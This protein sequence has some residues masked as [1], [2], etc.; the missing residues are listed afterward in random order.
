MGEKH[1]WRVRLAVTIKDKQY[2]SNQCWLIVAPSIQS[3]IK[4]AED[5]AKMYEYTS[6]S[7]WDVSHVGIVTAEA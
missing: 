4:K 2:S 3:A 1:V 6:A 5:V 7:V